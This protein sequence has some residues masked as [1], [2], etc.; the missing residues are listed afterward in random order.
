LKCPPC[1]KELP[2]FL[3][4]MRHVTERSKDGRGRIKFFLVSTDPLSDKDE[5]RKFMEEQKIDPNTELLLDPYRKACEK[6]GVTGIPRTFVISPQG[7]IAAEV[8]GSVEDYKT[9]LENG[10]SDALKA[11]EGK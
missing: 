11:E 6:F 7:R 2:L 4:V 5:L 1:R 3:E 9:L 8:A 10:I